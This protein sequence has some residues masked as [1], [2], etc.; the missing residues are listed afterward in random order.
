MTRRCPASFPDRLRL[1]RELVARG[2][3]LQP[4]HLADQHDAARDEARG[5]H[6]RIGELL[7]AV[8]P[9]RPWFYRSQTDA[10][11]EVRS[12]LLASV[13][14]CLGNVCC[15]LRKSG[16]QPALVLLPLARIVCT[17][18]AGIIRRPPPED[19][20]RCDVCGAR[21]VTIF[22]PFACHIGPMIV[23][24]DACPACATVLG[25]SL[26]ERTA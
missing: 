7:P 2:A 15:H 13:M 3:R 17:R 10:P 9:D 11:D 26:K 25:I 24:G 4:V 8:R 23:S 12:Y 20:D 6:D 18:C 16:P 5:L 19:A 21:G 22:S 14:G 1:A